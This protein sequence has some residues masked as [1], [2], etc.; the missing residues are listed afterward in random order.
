MSIEPCST[1]QTCN[2]RKLNLDVSKRS[3]I[4]MVREVGA[5]RAGGQAGGLQRSARTCRATIKLCVVQNTEPGQQ[6]EGRHRSW[7]PGFES[8]TTPCDQV[9]EGCASRDDRQAEYPR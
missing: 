6:L 7:C 4:S 1:G 5:G 2:G 8:W 3:K 9:G